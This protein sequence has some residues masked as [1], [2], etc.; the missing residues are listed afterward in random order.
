MQHKVLHICLSRGWG[1][2][3][4]YPAR[5]IPELARQGWRTY[6]LALEGTR[7][8]KT[9][10]DGEAAEVCSV[11][12]PTRALLQLPALVRWLRRIGIGVVHCHKSSDLRLGAL[13]KRLCPEL[14]L[15][16]TDHMGVT[17]PKQ[18]PY[19]RWVYR[20]VDRVLSISEA[21]LTRNRQAFPLPPSRITLLYLGIDT[22]DFVPQLDAA[23]RQALRD[24]LGIP[25]GAVTIALP[26]RLT[27]GK[28][29]QVLLDAFRRLVEAGDHQSHLV[30]IGGLEADEGGNPTFIASLQQQIHEQ[31]LGERVTFTGF[32]RDLA[33]LFEVMDIVCVPSRNEAFG[34]TVIEAMAAGKAVVGADSGAIPELLDAGS[35]RL[36]DPQDPAAWAATLSE[37][38]DAPALR[39]RLGDAACR[40]VNARFTL[41]HHVTGLRAIYGDTA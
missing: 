16:F 35:G 33:R 8:A 15:V 31:G 4:M 7:L 12:S 11:R 9:L 25:R 32:R 36:A 28:G 26:G 30:L 27:P 21:T 22:A 38:R 18:D 2:L 23:A 39:E 41:A 19:H 29:Q 10:V 6:V 37:L 20:H 34:L 1:G 40:L 24:A 17:R 5:I 14:R 13:L 3:E